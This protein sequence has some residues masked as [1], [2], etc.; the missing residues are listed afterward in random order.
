[1]V[2]LDL[3]IS[4]LCSGSDSRFELQMVLD[5]HSVDGTLFVLKLNMCI[6]VFVYGN[7][8]LGAGCQI[9]QARVVG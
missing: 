3:D 7:A 9:I 6:Y 2:E 8:D 5:W 1:M 4:T